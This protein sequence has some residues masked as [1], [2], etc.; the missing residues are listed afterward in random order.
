MSKV[1]QKS[2]SCI[3][4]EYEIA[5]EVPMVHIFRSFK[6]QAAIHICTLR[7]PKYSAHYYGVISNAKYTFLMQLVSSSNIFIA[8]YPNIFSFCKYMSSWILDSRANAHMANNSKLFLLYALVFC[9]HRH[10]NTFPTLSE[11]KKGSCKWVS[12]IAGQPSILP[13]VF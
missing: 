1:C 2:G 3:R 9:C 5:V 11:V 7:Y 4:I 13:F 6:S 12:D 10:R 8:A